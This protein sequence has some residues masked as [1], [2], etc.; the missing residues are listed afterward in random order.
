MSVSSSIDFRLY[1]NENEN[2]PLNIYF[3][4][5]ENTWDR[6]NETISFFPVGDKDD[7]NWESH[8]LNNEDIKNL[9]EKKIKLKELIGFQLFKKLELLPDDWIG[10]NLLFHEITYFSISLIINRK[11][12]VEGITDVNWYLLEMYKIVH[13]AGYEI[14]SIEFSEHV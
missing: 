13:H 11:K 7:C 10:V 3:S 1:G 9:I 12:T 2:I 6:Y 14:E 5:L 4:F 8:N